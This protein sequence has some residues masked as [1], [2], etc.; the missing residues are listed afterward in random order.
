MHG[1]I[2]KVPTFSLALTSVAAADG[3]G[4]KS[5]ILWY[6]RIRRAIFSKQP[7]W[8][9]SQVM[10]SYTPC[11]G[12]IRAIQKKGIRPAYGMVALDFLE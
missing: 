7:Y 9:E 8:R 10:V 2:V 12:I 1:V 4:G 11:Q 3:R 6:A 5:A